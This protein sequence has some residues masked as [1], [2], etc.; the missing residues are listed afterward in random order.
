MTTFAA[1]LSK[2]MTNMT[3]TNKT[4]RVFL[5]LVAWTMATVAQAQ[6]MTLGECIHMGIERNLQLQSQRID[7]RKGETQISQSRAMLL[8]QV[9]GSLQVIDYL[10]NP[11]QVSGGTLIGMDFPDPI[12]WQKVHSMPYSSQAML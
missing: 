12:N 7:I 3:I 2:Y 11:V 4:N 1:K 5:A 10:K 8:P 6:T 9:N